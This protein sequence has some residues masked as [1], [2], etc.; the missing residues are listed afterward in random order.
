MRSVIREL[1]LTALLVPAM[2]ENPADS[3]N[4]TGK[5]SLTHVCTSGRRTCTDQLCITL[6]GTI[7]G[8]RT[9]QPA[10]DARFMSGHRYH[11]SF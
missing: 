10:E 11:T 1:L 8:L 2:W 3:A 9:I 7:G 4:E 6:A 5:H